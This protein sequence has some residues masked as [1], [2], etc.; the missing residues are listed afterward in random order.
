[1]SYVTIQMISSPAFSKHV[2]LNVGNNVY[3]ICS[4][5]KSSVRIMALTSPKQTSLSQTPANHP[6]C[7]HPHPTGGC[8]L[9]VVLSGHSPKCMR[10][11]GME[12]ARAQPWTQRMASK[13]PIFFRKKI[14]WFWL[15]IW[16][17][18]WWQSSSSPPK[19][20]MGNVESGMHQSWWGFCT[21]L[22]IPLCL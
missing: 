21:S 17:W 16:N 8:V 12:R 13:G 22:I 14:I 11:L 5:I 1:M 19:H 4:L 18:L 3:C 20:E 15:S 7:G 10:G 2:L 9:L 6:R